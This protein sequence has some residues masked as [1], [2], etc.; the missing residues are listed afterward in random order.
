MGADHKA[1]IASGAGGGGRQAI[2]DDTRPQGAARAGQR[3]RQGD[4]GRPP[5]RARRQ[6]PRRDAGRQG[7]DLGSPVRPGRVRPRRRRSVQ[8]GTSAGSR[9]PAASCGT[10][11]RLRRRSSP[12]MAGRAWPRRRSRTPW[13]PS[14]RRGPPAR[15]GRGASS[16]AWQAT[17]RRWRACRRPGRTG[18]CGTTLN[19]DGR[20]DRGEADRLPQAERGQPARAVSA[21]P[22]QS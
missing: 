15:P 3:R 5:G 17:P 16:R 21:R 7:V 14:S 1:A 20:A 9:P 18:W 10:P 11:R 4:G 19:A 2:V 22:G 8:G 13:D 6:R 12:R